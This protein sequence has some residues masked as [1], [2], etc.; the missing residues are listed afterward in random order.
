MPAVKRPFATCGKLTGVVNESS[1]SAGSAMINYNNY[2]YLRYV[3]L[4]NIIAALIPSMRVK[5][6]ANDPLLHSTW[7]T[8]DQH[9]AVL[10]VSLAAIL[11]SA[12]VFLAARTGI[13]QWWIFVGCGIVAGDF[14]A[15]FYLAT[16]PD[17]AYLPL[18]EMY[19]DGTGCGVVAG[20][21]L[22]LLLRS[23]K[24]SAAA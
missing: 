5:G 12:L 7:W 4:I 9:S 6:R 17:N 23:R 10:V 19:V 11:S 3:L 20:A 1:R 24:R 22:T 14:P 18:T 2:V 8:M 13:R 15:T 21:V 16:T